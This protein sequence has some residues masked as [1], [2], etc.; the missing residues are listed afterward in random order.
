MRPDAA[1]RTLPPPSRVHGS[2]GFAR[3]ARRLVEKLGGLAQRWLLCRGS[4][5]AYLRRLG[6]RIGEEPTILN[7]V[8]DFGTEPWLIEIGSRVAIASGVVFITHDGAS[9]IFRD[10]IAGGSPFGNRFGTI[11]ILDG[12]FVGLRAIL[13]PGVTVGPESIVGAG[14]VVT[15]DVPPRTVAAGAPARVLCSLEEYIDEYRARLIPGL[16]S[17]RRELRRQLTRRLWGEER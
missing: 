13:L 9:R 2:P 11:R 10:R 14:S 1:L 16:S 17:S 15:R 4:K 12:S 6:T 8:S 3:T 5:V 7:R